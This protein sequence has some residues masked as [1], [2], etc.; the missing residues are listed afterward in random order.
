MIDFKNPT[1]VDVLSLKKL[2]GSIP[3]PK[4][5]ETKMLAVFYGF[6]AD[7]SSKTDERGVKVTFG[8]DFLAHSI[9]KLGKKEPT[10]AVMRAPLLVLPPVAAEKLM[11]AGIGDGR[12]VCHFGFRLGVQGED[13]MAGYAFISQNFIGPRT[14]SPLDELLEQQPAEHWQ[15]AG[16]VA[17]DAE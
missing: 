3:T 14:F 8:G 5:G 12:N 15:T 11:A 7:F 13:S 17:A 10:F 2:I 9:E 6:A 16:D 1:A 4:I